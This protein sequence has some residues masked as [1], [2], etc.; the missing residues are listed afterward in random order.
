MNISENIKNK[1]GIETCDINLLSFD[2]T[3]ENSFGIIEGDILY[4]RSD[5]I[6]E[7]CAEIIKKQDNL[8][9]KVNLIIHDSDPSMFVNFLDSVKSYDI[10]GEDVIKLLCRS[11]GEE[12]VE[13]ITEL[14]YVNNYISP[15]FFKRY[16][17]IYK[18]EKVFKDLNI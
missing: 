18:R 6:C 12:N 4:L 11:F 7:K 8:D 16:Y 10:D 3:I 9:F 15:N 2:T 14:E 13:K 5:K 1:I 17:T